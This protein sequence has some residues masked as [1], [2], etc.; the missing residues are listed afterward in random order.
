MTHQTE[1]KPFEKMIQVLDE[2]GFEGLAHALEIL[3]NEAMKIERSAVLGAQPYERTNER[4]GHAN[5]FKPK[6]LATRVGP[7]QLEIPQ[8]RGVKF[9]PQSLERGVRSD[10]ALKLAVAEMYVQGVSTRKV[11]EITRELCGLD[12]SS[13]QVSRVAQLLDEELQSWR[14]RLL[15]K[16]SYLLLD[17]RYEPRKVADILKRIRNRSCS[18][19]AVHLGQK[20]YQTPLK[21]V[22][23]S[24]FEPLTLLR[25]RQSWFLSSSDRSWQIVTTN[26]RWL[27]IRQ[28]QMIVRLVRLVASQGFLLNQP[29]P[30]LNMPESSA[31]KPPT[32]QTGKTQPPGNCPD[33]MKFIP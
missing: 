8:T 4:R 10:R 1:S 24:G 32:M 31:N 5:G 6:R 21:E 15:G 3:F 16:L 19:H 26:V 33:R 27:H 18:P 12:V 29:A 23:P 22:S 30:P 7:L 28:R 13:S 2:Y 11:T 20:E 14:S 25:R 17:A 9:Y